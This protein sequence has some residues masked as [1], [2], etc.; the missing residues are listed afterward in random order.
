MVV[1][2]ACLS[3]KQFRPAD[4]IGTTSQ[5]SIERSAAILVLL[6][7]ITDAEIPCFVFE[8]QIAAIETFGE[9]QRTGAIEGR[10]QGWHLRRS[11]RRDIARHCWREWQ[12]PM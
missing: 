8:A 10:H 11:T 9:I 12:H 6:L 5:D 4:Q 2:H 3:G 1:A 7:L